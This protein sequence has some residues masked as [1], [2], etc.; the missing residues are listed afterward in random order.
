[1]SRGPGVIPPRG[2][3]RWSR[4]RTSIQLNSYQIGPLHLSYGIWRLLGIILF[5]WSSKMCYQKRFGALL[6]FP[7]PL[8]EGFGIDFHWDVN[9]RTCR[10]DTACCERSDQ[11][12]FFRLL[13]TIDY[14]NTIVHT[15]Y[16][17][18]NNDYLVYSRYPYSRSLPMSGSAQINWTWWGG[19]WTITHAWGELPPGTAQNYYHKRGSSWVEHAEK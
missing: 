3:S 12:K 13:P 10:G 4:R 11:L 9:S 17:N 2:S 5:I 1:M 14:S 16:L 15:F 18:T 19:S 6:A 7:E 8:S